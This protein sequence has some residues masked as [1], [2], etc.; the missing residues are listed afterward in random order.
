MG[1]SLVYIIVLAGSHINKFLHTDGWYEMTK[2]L[3]D[4]SYDFEK[5]EIIT[6]FPD[7][8][9]ITTPFDWVKKAYANIIRLE[10]IG[11]LNTNDDDDEE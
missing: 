8:K 5:R 4:E 1:A 9:Y 10:E 3:P 7:G 2:K 6:K 11:V